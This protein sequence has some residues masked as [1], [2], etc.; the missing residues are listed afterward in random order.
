[1]LLSPVQ[2]RELRLLRRDRTFMVQTLLLPLMMVGA[3]LVLNVHADI[4][5]GAVQAPSHLSAI[6]FG[7]AAYT[8]MF[9]AFQTLNAD[10]QSL[11]I[12]FCLRR[13]LESILRQ[14][15]LLWGTVATLYAAAV[16]AAAI[17]LA[18]DV[19]WPLAANAAIVL[20]GVPVFA[21]IATALGVFGCDPLEQDVQK[22]VRITYLYL[23]MLIA[24]FYAFAIY[25]STFWA[26]IATMVLTALV[27]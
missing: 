22:R 15:A 24:S 11:W 9:S 4:F 17:A 21:V 3:Q 12:L 7:L 6:A 19:S 27:A 5:S 23:Y 16:F 20:A 8:L 14:K 26:R 13:S 2:R 1:A 10:V 18:R 25:A